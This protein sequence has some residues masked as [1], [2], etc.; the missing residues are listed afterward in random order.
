MR[1]WYNRI[2]RVIEI[3][4]LTFLPKVYIKYSNTQAK[5]DT[6]SLGFRCVCLIHFIIN[7]THTC[8]QLRCVVLNYPE[9][10]NYKCLSR[11]EHGCNLTEPSQSGSGLWPI[12]SN[13][14]STFRSDITE[15]AWI[16]EKM[17]IPCCLRCIKR[18]YSVRDDPD[19]AFTSSW[20]KLFYNRI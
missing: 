2:R 18:L 8:F 11:F 1:R 7:M 15:A 16:S 13:E 12:I 9:V 20:K 14:T 4:C 17:Q 5:V 3:H 6:K 10:A 19:V